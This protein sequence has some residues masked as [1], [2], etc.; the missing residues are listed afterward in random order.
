MAR[1]S[2]HTSSPPVWDRATRV[3]IIRPS[4]E[5]RSLPAACHAQ[6]V[7]VLGQQVTNEQGVAVFNTIYPGWYRG[8]ATHMHVKVHVGSS[9]TNMSGAIFAKGGHVSHTGQLYFN[10][11]MTDEV[12]KLSPYTSQ[13]VRRT[14]NAEDMLF[15]Q[16]KGSTMIIPVRLL[17]SNGLRGAVSG[18]ITLAINPNAVAKPD[19]G[20]GGGRPRSSTTP[21]GR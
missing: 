14:R 2:T 19:M 8:R 6:F 15:G 5:V 4:F 18:D 7:D 16:S 17:S 20:P 10:D 12:A 9:L 21:S 11:S 3:R 13:S 1:V